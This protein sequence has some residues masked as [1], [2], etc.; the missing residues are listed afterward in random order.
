[1]EAVIKVYMNIEKI[2]SERKKQ[3]SVFEGIVLKIYI[4]EVMINLGIID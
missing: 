4:Y 2:F 3:F 1:M